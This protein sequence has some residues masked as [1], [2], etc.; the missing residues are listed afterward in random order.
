M[1]IT[2]LYGE[3]YILLDECEHKKLTMNFYIINFLFSLTSIIKSKICF[4][5]MKVMWEIQII[6]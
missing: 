3:N 2:R 5:I 1:G 6:I 4:W